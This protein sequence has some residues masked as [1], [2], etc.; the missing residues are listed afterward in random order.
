M[1][2]KTYTEQVQEHLNIL[3]D[4]G[5]CVSELKLDSSS[6]IRC[7]GHEET[8]SRGEYSYISNTEQLGNG[9]LGIR[10][11]FRGPGGVG[12]HKTYGLPSSGN[13]NISIVSFRC[14]RHQR[15]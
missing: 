1:G 10:T 11:S 7:H 4:S 9:L 5:L 8:K 13:E 12:S 6:W 2:Y 15:K 14:Q 3:N